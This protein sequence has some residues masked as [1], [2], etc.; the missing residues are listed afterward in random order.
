MRCLALVLLIGCGSPADPAAD[1][2]AGDGA[3]PIDAPPGAMLLEQTFPTD[4]AAWPAGWA[5]LGGVASATVAN[6]RGALVP[7]L[8]SYSLAR[9][10][11]EL[12][13]TADL[14]ATFTL[15]LTSGAV[16]GVGFYVRQNG[17]YLRQ[18]PV[19][20]GGYAVFVEA[21]RGPQIGLWAERDG[22]EEELAPPF[23]PTTLADDVVYAVRFQVR[24]E[25][26]T[27]TRLSA[28]IWPAAD[29]EPAA[30]TIERSDATPALQN[31]GGAIAVDS[32]NNTT[33]GPTPPP[34]TVDD[35]VV[36]AL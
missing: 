11:H 9:M 3:P 32:W 10:G 27:S 33:A 35:I 15:T 24:Q 13:D 12:G 19:H 31:L 29:A 16:Q 2:P 4:G 22:V 36:R 21:F 34:I 5:A 23:A 25:S 7:A 26:A 20:G 6:G 14:E 17:G 30:W 1:A 28:R 18:S 8:S